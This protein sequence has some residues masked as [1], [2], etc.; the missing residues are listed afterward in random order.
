MDEKDFSEH[1][2]IALLPITTD[3]CH[4]ELPHMTLVYAG[5]INDLRRTAQ[6]DISKDAAALAMVCRPLTLRV[7]GTDVFGDDLEKVDVLR[8][9]TTSELLAMR[10]FV[11]DW[12]KSVHP[13]NP[14]VTIGPAGLNPVMQPSHLAFDRSLV[15]WGNDKLTFWLRN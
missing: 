10:H 14:H 15:S 7:T 12:N 8:L 1:V 3:W 11:D 13:F 6:N 4:I 9:E 5:K 2:M